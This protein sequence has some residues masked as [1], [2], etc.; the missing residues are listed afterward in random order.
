V[1]SSSCPAGSNP[2]VIAVSTSLGPG[3]A[4]VASVTIYGIVFTVGAAYTLIASSGGAQVS[5]QLIS[6]P[7]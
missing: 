1:I 3:Q 5:L 4:V 7:A 2:S 6:V